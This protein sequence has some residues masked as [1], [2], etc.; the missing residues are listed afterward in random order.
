M[1]PQSGGFADGFAFRTDQSTQQRSRQKTNDD[2]YELTRF[3]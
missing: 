3:R 2:G 1:C